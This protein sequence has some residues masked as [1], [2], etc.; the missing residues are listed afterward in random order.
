MS[1]TMRKPVFGARGVNFYISDYEDVRALY[2]YFSALPLYDR[3][4]FSVSN[5]MNSSP[6]HSSYYFNSQLNLQFR[7]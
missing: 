1:R 7:H 5:Y 6:I 3:V 4:C 2:V